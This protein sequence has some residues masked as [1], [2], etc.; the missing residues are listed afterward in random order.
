MSVVITDTQISYDNDLI[1]LLIL[2]RLVNL[3]SKV[4]KSNKRVRDL[5]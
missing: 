3:T 4:I 1:L 2:L 5:Q